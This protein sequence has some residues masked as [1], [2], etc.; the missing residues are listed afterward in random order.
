MYTVQLYCWSGSGAGQVYTVHC[1][2]VLLL[3]PVT[4]LTMAEDTGGSR[5]KQ[6]E[7]LDWL[8]RENLRTFTKRKRSEVEASP[9]LRKRVRQ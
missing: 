4:S 9:Q 7:E 5:R 8:R 6:E 2:V 1:T 3:L